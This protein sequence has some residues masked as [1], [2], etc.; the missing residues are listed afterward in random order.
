VSERGSEG[1]LEKRNVPCSLS[2]SP[3]PNSQKTCLQGVTMP[4][5]RSALHLLQVGGASW[6]GP[7]AAMACVEKENSASV[8]V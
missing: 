3:S 5:S 2:L 1:A 8:C 4:T 7:G 6:G